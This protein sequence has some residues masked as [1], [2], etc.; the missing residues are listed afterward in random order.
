MLQRHEMNKNNVDKSMVDPVKSN[1]KD[2]EGEIGRGWEERGAGGVRI[3][4]EGGEGCKWKCHFM[5]FE[6]QTTTAAA[7]LSGPPVLYSI[8]FLFCCVV[9]YPVF[10]LLC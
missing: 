8:V 10:P 7:G 6:S 2:G 1:Q 4:G 9:F 3:R 5:F